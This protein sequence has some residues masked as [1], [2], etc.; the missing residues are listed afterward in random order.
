LRSINSESTTAAIL[1]SVRI[2]IDYYYP[3]LVNWETVFHGNDLV[4][5]YNEIMEIANKLDDSKSQ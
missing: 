2:L 1:V 5:F 4:N 3:E